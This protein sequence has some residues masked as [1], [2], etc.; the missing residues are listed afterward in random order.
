MNSLVGWK[1]MHLINAFMKLFHILKI[2]DKREL[3]NNFIATIILFF[4]DKIKVRDFMKARL[5]NSKD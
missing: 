5:I 3:K 4:M 1:S 2:L